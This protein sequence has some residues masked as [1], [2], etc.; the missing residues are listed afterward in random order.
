[1]VNIYILK[2]EHE[3]WY[4]GKT[5]NVVVRLEDHSGGK[6]VEWTKTHR[7]RE[8]EGIVMECDDFDEDKYVKKYMAEYGIDNVRGGSYVQTLL[9]S[10]QKDFLERDMRSAMNQCFVCGHQGHFFKECVSYKRIQ[11]ASTERN[12]KATNKRKRE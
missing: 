3:K 11:P 2:L 5:M 9:S 6:G 4:V 1:M 8:I 7:P 12:I 10:Q